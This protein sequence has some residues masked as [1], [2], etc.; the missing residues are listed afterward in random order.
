M[1]RRATPAATF[2][3]F[4]AKKPKYQ[5]RRFA[6]QLIFWFYVL[7]KTCSA[8]PQHKCPAKIENALHSLFL[9][10]IC[11]LTHNFGEEKIR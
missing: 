2:W 9:L 6:P 1:L 3:G 8:I 11:T 7:S 4:I 5:L 10:D